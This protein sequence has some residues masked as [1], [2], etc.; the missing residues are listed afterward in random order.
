MPNPAIT[1]PSAL[2]VT[3]QTIDISGFSA[4]QKDFEQVDARN[5]A[6]V[7]QTK[8]RADKVIPPYYLV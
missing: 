8:S 5:S 6:L 7:L 3:E 4:G 1:F 2:W